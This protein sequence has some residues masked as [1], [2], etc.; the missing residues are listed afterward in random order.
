M[1]KVRHR[2]NFNKLEKFFNRVTNKSYLNILE[3]YGEKGV[4]ALRK[5]T[6]VDS[7]KTADS[8]MFEIR[9]TRD[10]TSISFLNTNVNDGVNIA[11]ILRYGHGTGTGGFVRGIN[12]IDPAIQPIFEEMAEELW[13]EVTVG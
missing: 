7:G 1:I 10:T 9:H 13:R 6:P 5:N 8:W 11:L 3:K 12:Y 4:E 2:G